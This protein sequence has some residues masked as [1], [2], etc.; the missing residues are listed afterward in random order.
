VFYQGTTFV[1][2]ILSD[3]STALVP[4]EEKQVNFYGDEITAVLVEVSGQRQVYIPVRP[5]SEY[6]GLAWSAQLQRMKRDEVLTEGLTS[7]S[8]MNTEV[9]QRYDVMCLQ[10]EFLPGWLFGISAS[11]V[12]PDLQ[13]KIKRYRR[14]CYRVLWQAFQADVLSMVNKDEVF[15]RLAEIHR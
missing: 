14:E 8:V 5:I 4:I 12:R 6:L 15:R 13:D 2:C 10:L 9:K 7:V 3:E 11:R 1:R